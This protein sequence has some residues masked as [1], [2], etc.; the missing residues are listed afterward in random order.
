MS[1]LPVKISSGT[2]PRTFHVE[3]DAAKMERL[4][5]AFGL[6]NPDLLASIE[7]AE[8]DIRAGRVQKILSFRD[9]RC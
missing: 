9:L 2:R 8:G 1:S 3:V 5:S 4:A 6:F 7:R